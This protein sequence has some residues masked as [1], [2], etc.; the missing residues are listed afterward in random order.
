MATNDLFDFEED[1]AERENEE[2]G[3]EAA[4]VPRAH[5]EVDDARDLAGDRLQE[6]HV[7]GVKPVD[8]FRLDGQDPDPLAMSK[9]R[10]ASEGLEALFTGFGEEDESW[11][12]VGLARQV[13]SLHLGDRCVRVFRDSWSLE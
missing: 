9:E 3:G 8:R 2:R 10:N 11:V 1:A 7:V 5:A 4:T 13:G 12:L 6:D